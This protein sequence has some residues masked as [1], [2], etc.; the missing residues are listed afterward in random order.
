MSNFQRLIRFEDAGGTIHYGELGDSE[1]GVSGYSGL[2]VDT[3][4]G[5]TPWSRNFHSMGK[6]VVIER[7]SILQKTAYIRVAKKT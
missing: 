7:V 4:E 1:P 2:E 5:E 3:Y 6:K